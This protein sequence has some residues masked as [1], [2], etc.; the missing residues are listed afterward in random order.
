MP[1]YKEYCIRVEISKHYG[2]FKCLIFLCK[3]RM[4]HLSR[5][6]REVMTILF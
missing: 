2:I 4:A 3:S 5:H 1:E 6:C